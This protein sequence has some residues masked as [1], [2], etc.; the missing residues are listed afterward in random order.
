MI[1]FV[2]V[3]EKLHRYLDNMKIDEARQLAL[4][5]Y[6]KKGKSVDSDHM[7]IT[8]EFDIEYRRK[9]PP[10]EEI[11]NFRNCQG[12]N[13]FKNIFAPTNSGHS[14]QRPDLKSDQRC[15]VQV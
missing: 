7:T 14:A 8:A 1:D 9:P 6:L 15:I 13:A 2:V 5:S 10:R 3:C 4:T 12:L 11:F